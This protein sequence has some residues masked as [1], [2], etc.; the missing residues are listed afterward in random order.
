MYQT[1]SEE[2]RTVAEAQAT[3]KHYAAGDAL[4]RKGSYISSAVIVVEGMIKIFRVDEQ[5]NSHFLY[6]LSAGELCVLSTLCC[7]RMRQADMRAV[8]F[9]DCEVMFIPSPYPEV[10][11]QEYP[12]WSRYLLQSF[13]QRMAELLDTFDS[14]VFKHLDERLLFYLHQHYKVSGELLYLSHQQIADEL[15]SSREVISRLLKRLED[16]G[17]VVVKRSFVRIL[18]KIGDN[19]P[20]R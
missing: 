19:R 7:L 12:E 16:E 15:N 11:M 4:F 17:Y 2:L 13:N 9:T 3:F 14:V 18:P 8:A 6:F 1:L 10:W 20:Q 5:G